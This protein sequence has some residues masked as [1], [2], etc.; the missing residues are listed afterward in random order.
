MF[1]CLIIFAFP[2][3]AV[4]PDEVLSDPLLEAR[5]RELS[6]EIRCLVCQNESIDSSNAQLAKDLRLLVR[7][8]LVG[9]DSDQQV[10]DYLVARYGDFVLLRPPV[11]PATYILWFGPAVVFV[12]GALAVASYFVRLKRRADND[13]QTPLSAQEKLRLGQIL[14]DTP[15]EETAVDAPQTAT[16][17]APSGRLD[18]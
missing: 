13:V 6:K 2:T 14:A 9:G 17:T 18:S 8:R 10:L 15:Q 5:A 4:E 1:L 3:L 12:L 11:K 16:R 7:E